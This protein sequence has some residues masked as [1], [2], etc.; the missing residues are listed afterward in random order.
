[1]RFKIKTMKK[2]ILSFLHFSFIHS[3]FFILS[4]LLHACEEIP[5]TL[6]PIDPN[7]G[8]GG[9]TPR[10]VLIEE[11][12]GVKCVNCPAGSEAIENLITIYK[13]QLIPISIH[14]GFFAPPYAESKY[15]FRTTDGNN[16]LSY[17]GEP[18]GY[19]TAVV[20]RKKFTGEFD[21]Q[22][23]QNQWAGFIAQE[24]AQ[25]PE[26]SLTLNK[27][28]NAATRRLEVNVNVKTLEP[29]DGSDI[30]LSVALTE[31]NI[32]DVQLAPGGKVNDY[33]HKHVLRDFITNYDGNLIPEAQKEGAIITKSFTYDIPEAW[34]AENCNI[35]VFVHLNGERK[36]VL[37]A[38]QV[39]VI[40]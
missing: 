40:Q 29:I 12:S 3:S 10:K 27:I 4:L 13:D 37:Q 9:P 8:G 28:Y 36:D 5:P 33:K 16:L 24:A 19:P 11:F 20:N 14:A 1:M 17:L 35:V 25:A 39:K 31:T 26:I 2:F 23:A 32:I 6:N 22:L 15:D 30:R 18:L 7:S 21:I 34:V 38:E